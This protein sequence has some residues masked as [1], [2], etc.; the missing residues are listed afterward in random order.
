MLFQERK[1]WKQK[2]IQP[3]IKKNTFRQ[4]EN[5]QEIQPAQE[6]EWDELR[7]RH[8]EKSAVS[9]EKTKKLLD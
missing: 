1:N 4:K 2:K 7:T 6:E 3:P 9:Q 8:T 5:A